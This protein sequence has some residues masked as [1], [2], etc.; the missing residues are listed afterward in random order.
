ML[1]K[2]NEQFF[3]CMNTN[4]TFYL[5]KGKIGV[6][7]LGTCWRLSMVAYGKDIIIAC[8]VTKSDGN[9]CEKDTCEGRI[10]NENEILPAANKMISAICES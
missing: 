4:A 8:F 10:W 5:K 7:S 3:I 2:I 9:S 1:K 6:M